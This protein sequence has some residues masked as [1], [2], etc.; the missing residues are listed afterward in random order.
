[1]AGICLKKAWKQW[2]SKVSGFWR[3]Q[4]FHCQS[5]DRSEA[6]RKSSKS[7]CVWYVTRAR[8]NTQHIYL[9]MHLW[10]FFFFETIRYINFFKPWKKSF[11]YSKAKCALHFMCWLWSKLNNLVKSLKEFKTLSTILHCSFFLGQVY[12]LK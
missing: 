12:H 10:F 8:L 3:T 6:F 2:L 7:C 9:R 11:P 4:T 5:T 1:M